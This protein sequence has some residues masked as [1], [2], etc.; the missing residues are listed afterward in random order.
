MHRLPPPPHPPPSLFYFYTVIF[1]F[2]FTRFVKKESEFCSFF[3]SSLANRLLVAFGV[4]FSLIFLYTGEACTSTL[5]NIHERVYARRHGE[6]TRTTNAFNMNN[7]KTKQRGDT[8]YIAQTTDNVLSSSCRGSRNGT[9]STA[10]RQRHQRRRDVVVHR[11]SGHLPMMKGKGHHPFSDQ[12]T[13]DARW[14]MKHLPGW[15]STGTGEK[16]G[17]C[18]DTLVQVTNERKAGYS[19]SHSKSTGKKASNTIREER[20]RGGQR[21]VEV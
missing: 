17:R 5:Y 11:T 15:R 12:K 18:I 19:S 3:R 6:K 2:P 21:V 8:G 13:N 9:N 7:A 16:N 4:V 14:I 10:F 20:K 1:A